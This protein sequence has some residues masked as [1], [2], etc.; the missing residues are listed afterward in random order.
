M[1]GPF[2][3]NALSVPAVG[4]HRSESMN[5]WLLVLPSQYTVL[6]VWPTMAVRCAARRIGRARPGRGSLS[7]CA[8][9]AT[10]P[11]VFTRSRKCMVFPTRPRR[12]RICRERARASPSD[13]RRK[14]AARA[15]ALPLTEPAAGRAAS[16]WA[17]SPHLWVVVCTR[18]RQNYGPVPNFLGQ[19]GGRLK[20]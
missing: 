15:R 14:D 16:W 17:L 3:A 1:A 2:I 18:S 9:S 5:Q 20:L 12:R 19:N 4:R 13:R 8:A 11:R 10:A 7:P 6:C